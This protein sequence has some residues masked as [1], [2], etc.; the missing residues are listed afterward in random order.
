[1]ATVSLGCRIPLPAVSMASAIASTAWA[2]VPHA[3]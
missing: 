2:W 1:M 3:R